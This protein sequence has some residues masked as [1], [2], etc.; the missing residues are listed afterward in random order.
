MTSTSHQ[1]SLMCLSKRQR[2]ICKCGRG[3]WEIWVAP[4][5]FPVSQD[6]SHSQGGGGGGGG[7]NRVF[8]TDREQMGTV[9]SPRASGFLS[10]FCNGAAGPIDTHVGP[11]Q[12]S[13][14]PSSLTS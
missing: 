9:C 1:M 11:S 12:G 4:P 6:S 2:P 7:N 8:H 3:F 14:S 10:R 13:D 5:L